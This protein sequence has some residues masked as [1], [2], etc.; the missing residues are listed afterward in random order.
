M[1]DYPLVARRVYCNAN[2]GN[3]IQ[4]GDPWPSCR[5]ILYVKMNVICRQRRRKLF[6]KLRE[7]I[8]KWAFFSAVDYPHNERRNIAVTQT[9]EVFMKMAQ[10]TFASNYGLNSAAIA[11]RRPTR[12]HETGSSGSSNIRMPLTGELADNQ[13]RWISSPSSRYFGQSKA[14]TGSE[15]TGTKN[16]V[17]GFIFAH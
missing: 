2:G 13:G 14:S 10:S 7:N 15:T 12:S 17:D 16:R 3:R 4:N 9:L 6:E 11:R 1:S 5:W 8:A